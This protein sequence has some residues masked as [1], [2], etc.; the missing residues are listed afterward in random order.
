MLFS[1]SGGINN[2]ELFNKALR[3]QHFRGQPIQIAGFIG[4]G[5]KDHLGRSDIDLLAKYSR[6]KEELNQNY[7]FGVEISLIGADA[8]GWSNSM[9]D[10]GYLDLMQNEAR[11]RDFNWIILSD[12]YRDKGLILPTWT[13]ASRQLYDR[14][15]EGYEAWLKINSQIREDLIKQAGKHHQLDEHIGERSSNVLSAFYYFLM[16]KQEE[17][18]FIPDWKNFLFVING[19]REL[20][21]HT[22]PQSIAQMY[23]YDTRH[24]GGR[25]SR[26]KNENMILPPP[27][28]RND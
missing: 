14:Q 27:W 6:L 28:F 8:H 11:S 22:F 1:S 4:Q 3:E 2:Q 20:A 7:P 5:G 9:P 10:Y 16:R 24:H 26:G 19:S 21:E 12:L 17:K 18:I 15:G 25:K 23:W 13:E